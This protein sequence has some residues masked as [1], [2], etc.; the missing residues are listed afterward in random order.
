MTWQKNTMACLADVAE[1]TQLGNC[2]VTSKWISKL[3]R[4][5]KT[6]EHNNAN[7]AST[8]E[9]VNN[10]DLWINWMDT[11]VIQNIGA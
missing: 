9:A 2:S 1:E 8:K 7:S 3:V 5:Q 11:W 4:D 6:T 10:Y